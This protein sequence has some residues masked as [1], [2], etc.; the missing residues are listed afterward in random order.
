MAR[1]DEP[2]KSR[3]QLKKEAAALQKTGEKLVMLA[4]DQL[5]R[6]RL[7]T[8]LMEAIQAVRPMK[9]HGARRRQMQYIGTLMRSLD[10]APIEQALMELEQGAYR[11]TQAF[12]H[13]EAVRDQLVAGNDAVFDEIL[14]TFPDVDRQRLGQLVRSARKEKQKNAPPKS[15]RN[16][17]RYL[18]HLSA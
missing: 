13:I 17:F 16:L 15:A 5:K 8:A 7:P 9:S 1:H 10:V 11:L 3:T 4:D 14:Q 12:H 18:K 6:M 2:E